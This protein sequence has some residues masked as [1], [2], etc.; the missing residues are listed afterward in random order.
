[1]NQATAMRISLPTFV[2]SDVAALRGGLAAPVLGAFALVLIAVGTMFALQLRAVSE[3]DAT[4]DGARHAEEVLGV[5]NALERRVIDV[6][7]G[8]R[9]YL[10]TRREVFLE[11]F[12][13]GRAEI[14]GELDELQQLAAV[15]AQA[16]RARELRAAVEAYLRTYAAPVRAH[17]ATMPRSRLLDVSAQGKAQVDALRGRFDAF[18]AAEEGL[19]R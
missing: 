13:A 9:G 2:K 19:A 18:N 11:P 5:S 12:D 6:E 10:L 4:A 8:L 3:L 16:R 1:M 7:T 14:P 15:P 17:G